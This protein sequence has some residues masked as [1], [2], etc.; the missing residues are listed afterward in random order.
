MARDLAL[1]TIT[2]ANHSGPDEG[3]EPRRGQ[4]Y[5]QAGECFRTAR[6]EAGRREGRGTDLKP[7]AGDL[8]HLR[9]CFSRCSVQRDCVQSRWGWR[10]E[11]WRDGGW[12]LC[13]RGEGFVPARRH[14]GLGLARCWSTGLLPLCQRCGGWDW[15]RE[16]KWMS[17]G[18]PVG[19]SLGSLPRSLLCNL[20]RLLTIDR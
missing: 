3:L 18:W 6:C 8:R 1:C 15:N 14:L 2:A 9:A 19:F 12:A 5:G 10:R 13:S 11:D 4:G 7:T 17:P 20:C 16:W